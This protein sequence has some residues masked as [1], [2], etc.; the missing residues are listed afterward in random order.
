ATERRAPSNHD[1]NGSYSFKLI[2]HR[3]LKQRIQARAPKPPAVRRE[4]EVRR[5]RR[6]MVCAEEYRLHCIPPRPYTPI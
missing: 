2:L 4:A 1:C 3:E 6:S 5:C